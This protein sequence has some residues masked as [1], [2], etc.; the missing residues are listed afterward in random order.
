MKILL[1]LLFLVLFIAPSL[2]AEELS[3]EPEKRPI[4][5]KVSKGEE[6][7]LLAG[8]YRLDARE[9]H[10]IYIWNSDLVQNKNRIYPGQE[11]VIYVD[12]NWT[13]PYDLDEYIRSIGRR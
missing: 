7:H 12:N 13:P 9:W 1:V 4:V 3:P 6:L 8:Y 10:K 2:N 11:L 5:H